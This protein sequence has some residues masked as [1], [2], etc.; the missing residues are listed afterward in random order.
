MAYVTLSPRDAFGNPFPTHVAVTDKSAPVSA[1]ATALIAG[2]RPTV[3]ANTAQSVSNRCLMTPRLLSSAPGLEA[4]PGTYEPHE[5]PRG[6]PLQNVKS[7]NFE[8]P[9]A[10]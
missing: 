3:T 4:P 5:H 2:T 10:H 7:A 6:Q 8:Q 9:R 1:T